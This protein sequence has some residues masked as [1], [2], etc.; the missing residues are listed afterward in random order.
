[1]KKN[2]MIL[3]VA[4]AAS[5][6]WAGPVLEP[7]KMEVVVAAKAPRPV[8]FAAEELT[9]FLSRAFASAVPVVS[10][11]SE[12]KVS[13]VL[14]DNEWS[15]AAGIDVARSPRDTFAV[16]T[17]GNRVFIVGRDE[18]L[19]P[20]KALEACER[21]TLLGVYAFLEDYIGCRFY[22]PGEL[23]E[24]VP[25]LGLLKLPDIDRRTIPDFLIRCYY[26]SGSDGRWFDP[27]VDEAQAKALNWLRIRAS[28]IKIPCCHGMNKIDLAV[29]YEKT[30][31]E[32]FALRKDGTRCT[33]FTG[34]H[35]SRKG[36]PCFSNQGLKDVVV[37]WC[38]EQASK[39]AKFVDIMPNDALPPCHCPDCQAAYAKSGEDCPMSELVWGYTKYVAD[40][41]KEKK[42]DVIVTQMA[43]TEY[44]RIPRGI[45]IPDNVRVMVAEAGPWSLT[46]PTAL[47]NEYDEIR[48]WKTK[49]G[50]P[51]WIWTYP[52]KYWSL[53][54][55]GLPSVAPKAW[56]EYYK[57]LKGDILGTFAESETD[58]WLYHYL[59]YYV[60]TRVMW[61]ADTDID[62]V[63]N[64][65]HRLMFGAAAE[66]MKAF[67]E[68]L[69]YKWTHQL[70]GKMKNT[71]L[72]PVTVP[73][74]EP[75]IWEQIYSRAETDRLSA[76]LDKAAASVA[77]GSLEARRIALVRR[78]YLDPAIAAADAY[79]KRR[80]AIKALVYD[81]AKGKPIELRPFNVKKGREP[82]EY[83]KTA[84]SVGR[85][86]DALVVRYEA[87]DNRMDDLQGTKRVLDDPET[88]LDA[89]LEIYLNPSADL[90]TYYHI[91][92]NLEG[93]VSDSKGVRTGASSQILDSS[94]NSGAE[95]KIDKRGDGW[96][97]EVR[98]P[99][100]SLGEVK[101]AFPAEFVRN[102]N[103]RS[104]KGQC[105][106][107][108][109]PYVY[110]FNSLD[111]F[112][113]IRP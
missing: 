68:A 82:A 5:C 57:P 51:I 104:G 17:V 53:A 39:G 69:E 70:A 46:N 56:G 75:E 48:A 9:N 42:I 78:E 101:D 7:G 58:R 20:I 62:A 80:D 61:N 79:V 96:T 6:A 19:T 64:E 76:L 74:T 88:W 45:D 1:M 111:Q 89:S 91:I 22:F 21:A 26:N 28:T 106:Y 27:S 99:L 47:K 84:V 3:A 83:V 95:V 8:T 98:I 12:G 34:Y 2:V 109:S 41:L 31:P 25:R 50:N 67:Y 87:E 29:K 112:G 40:K 94:W 37:D 4:V 66:P 73:P 23:G 113:T 63:L 11:P 107:N 49:S 86:A 93:S 10:S 36:Y 35:S 102:R 24:I 30:H 65:H 90:T 15:R 81:A 100:K 55:P 59:N 14:G 72:G 43:Y 32:Y 108:W 60:F 97:A 85:T 71:P 16:K 110:S 33:N 77:E 92:V 44:R 103:T 54:V 13:I 105:L 38:V 18:N 52:H